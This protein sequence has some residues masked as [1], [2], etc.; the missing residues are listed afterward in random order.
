MAEMLV[1]AIDSTHK[2]TAKDRRGCYKRGMC[3]AVFEDGHSWGLEEGLP[4]FFVLRIP[5]IPAE[6]LRKYLEPQYENFTSLEGLPITHRRRLW[7]IM[8]DD[9]PAALRDKMLKGGAITIDARPS[10]GNY[11]VNWEHFRGNFK[12]LKTGA[13]EDGEL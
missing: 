4:K 13:F 8:V 1:K 2:D 6:K 10:G 7:K 3:V 12:N 9:A 11:D 5:G